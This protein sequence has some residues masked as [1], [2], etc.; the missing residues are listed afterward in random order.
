M[1]SEITA[2]VQSLRLPL[3]LFTRKISHLSFLPP[4]AETRWRWAA[5]AQA[6]AEYRLGSAELQSLL[7]DLCV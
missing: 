2:W 1:Q 4:A 7:R 3:F 6:E 5:P